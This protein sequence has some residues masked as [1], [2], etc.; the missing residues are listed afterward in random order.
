M[1]S[2][3]HLSKTILGNG[4]V[5]NETWLRGC[6]LL[7][8]K[9]LYPSYTFYPDHKEVMAH[10][11]SERSFL[12]LSARGSGKTSIGTAVR[13]WRSIKFPYSRTAVCSHTQGQANKILQLLHIQW[14]TNSFLKAIFPN[15]YDY[16]KSKQD[17]IYYRIKSKN[18]HSEPNIWCAG[19][20]GQ[21][22]QKHF[23]FIDFDD[24]VVGDALSKRQRDGLH[25]ILSSD[26][27]PTLV[28]HPYAQR[29]YYGTRYHVDDEY[30]RLLSKGICTNESS[31]D[32]YQNGRSRYPAILSD[33]FL[34]RERKLIGIGYFSCQYQMRPES[35]SGYVIK[36]DWLHLYDDVVCSDYILSIDIASTS[37]NYS[38]YTA[39]TVIGYNRGSYYIRDFVRGKWDN[40]A[41]ITEAAAALISKYK[42]TKAVCEKVGIQN[43]I[44]SYIREHLSIPV[45]PFKRTKNKMHYLRAILPYIE[46]GQLYIWKTLH[47]VVDELLQFPNGMYDD[48]VDTITQGVIFLSR[49]SSGSDYLYSVSKKRTESLLY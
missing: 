22:A 20:S 34:E 18:M 11:L 45:Y 37:S 30:G 14:K 41:K 6:W 23:E 5:Y 32:I 49:T 12:F 19:V 29:L 26:V 10:L 44:I 39:M 46:S 16:K 27:Y 4:N 24:I 13:L 7:L 1:S 31:W 3:I 43:L 35:L 8:T 25:A 42:I 38:D 40:V 33:Q 36:K 17:E 48:I 21:W 28:D 9:I 15:V 2:L 47:D